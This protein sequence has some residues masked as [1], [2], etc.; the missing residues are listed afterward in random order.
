[1]PGLSGGCFLL[2]WTSAEA[3]S[4]I[5]GKREEKKENEMAKNITAN[6][7]RHKNQTCKKK[8]DT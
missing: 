3:T 6:P 1:M 4:T 5:G 7:I 8:K 2:V